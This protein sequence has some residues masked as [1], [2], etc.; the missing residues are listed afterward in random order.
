MV[1]RASHQA[2]LAAMADG[3]MAT[4]RNAVI[5]LIPDRVFLSQLA[6]VAAPQAGLG[7]GR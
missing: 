1:H 7:V 6:Q 4:V 3:A 2:S 5:P